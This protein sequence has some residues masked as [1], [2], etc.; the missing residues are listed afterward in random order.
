MPHVLFLFQKSWNHFGTFSQ[1]PG[2]QTIASRYL[3]A[4][5][6]KRNIFL[7]P[8]GIF[9]NKN[10]FSSSILY[11]AYQSPWQPFHHQQQ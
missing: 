3:L 6:T 7:F 1:T 8:T 4:G 11:R 9:G 5:A 2:Y 10:P